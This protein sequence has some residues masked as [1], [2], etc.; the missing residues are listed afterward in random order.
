M[1]AT[2]DA[3]APAMVGS[4]DWKWIWLGLVVVVYLA[5]ALPVVFLGRLTAILVLSA[6][7]RRPSQTA[8]RSERRKVG[9]RFDRALCFNPWPDH[10]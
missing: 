8:P 1:N 2:P 10:R 4:S 3:V 9:A 5:V 6:F 7:G